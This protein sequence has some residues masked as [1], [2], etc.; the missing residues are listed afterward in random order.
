MIVKLLDSVCAE[1]IKR[2]HL[3]IS[4]RRW[5]LD[6]LAVVVGSFNSME[7]YE[8]QILQPFGSFDC[9]GSGSEGIRFSQKDLLL[10]S[11][12]FRVPEINLPSD[13][14]SLLWQ[15]QEP[16][17]GQLHLLTAQEFHL[18]PT[19]VRC[20]DPNTGILICLSE[21]SLIVAGERLRLRIAENFDLLFVDQKLCG[22]L[23]SS[24]EQYLVEIWETPYPTEA[25]K[26]FKALLYESLALVSEPKIQRF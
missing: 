13:K 11:V 8:R 2:S 24:A 20:F 10:Q 9:M 25:D 21:A 14:V 15:N 5:M 4:P 19:D 16:Q 26:E 17:I 23:L 18:Y 22:F 6:R 1:V 12:W 3:Q 7:E